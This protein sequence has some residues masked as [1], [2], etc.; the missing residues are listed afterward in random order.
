MATHA[1]QV[2]MSHYLMVRMAW[3]AVIG[4]VGALSIALWQAL[5]EV[6]V[7]RAGAVRT[8]ELVEH[9][10][11]LQAGSPEAFD[12]NLKALREAC[13]AGDLR[14][15]HLKL[16]TSDGAV[17]VAP[18]P[19][20]EPAIGLRLLFGMVAQMIEPAS[21]AAHTWEIRHPDGATLQASLIWNPL[22]EQNEIFAGV[23]GL[24][25]LLSAS[26]VMILASLY[27]AQRRALAPLRDIVHAITRFERDDY[28]HRL[29]PMPTFELDTIARSLNHL[30]G[31][32]THTEKVRRALSL[33]VL[34]L[35]EDE[36]A[37]LAR[38]LHDELGQVL[39]AMRA[40]IAYLLRKTAND[41]VLLDVV[42]DLSNHCERI[43]LEVCDLLDRLRPHGLTPGGGPVL[44]ERMLHDLV[45]SWRAHPGQS[46][47]F[48]LEIALHGEPLPDAL[49]VSL[50][51]M[52]QEAL[53]NV[54]RHAHA[55]RVRIHLTTGTDGEAHW[56][57]E[58]DGIGIPVLARALQHSNGLSGIQE[59]VWAHGGQIVMSHA[60]QHAPRKGLRL[61]ARFRRGAALPHIDTE[62]LI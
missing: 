15:L 54:V 42:Q 4:V 8:A 35:Q 17:L 59:R 33:K 16:T 19:T 27:W 50:Y 56:T 31:A 11:K 36:R 55:T 52:T 46:I 39:A 49:A 62:T 28:A 48:S 30:A 23:V 60:R 2:G 29:P 10:S 53:T 12:E 5:G 61:H 3:I 21:G 7:E 51:R 57:V 32:L 45:N 20:H 43:Q 9:L 14:H 44:L 25:L 34:T 13:N 40:D 47:D 18:P 38:E 37:R 6:R 22:S 24:L 26:S 1:K 58:D 41:A